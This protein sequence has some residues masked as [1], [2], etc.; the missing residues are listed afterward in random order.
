MCWSTSFFPL[1]NIIFFCLVFRGYH[2]FY[3]VI[4]FYG[5]KIISVHQQLSENHLDIT[6][7]EINVRS[8]FYDRLM[9]LHIVMNKPPCLINI[10]STSSI[11][12]LFMIGVLILLVIACVEA[13]ETPGSDFIESPPYNQRNSLN[14]IVNQ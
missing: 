13:E 12:W 7:L 3:I 5:K 14:F 11:A 2:V 4:L 9:F 10:S 1:P 8:I 6:I